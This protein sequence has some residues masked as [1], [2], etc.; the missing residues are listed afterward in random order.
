MALSKGVTPFYAWAR[1]VVQLHYCSRRRG[2][3][4]RGKTKSTLY[5]VPSTVAA[6]ACIIC[7]P[8]RCT[9]PQLT[10]RW[11]NCIGTAS[12]HGITNYKHFS[13]RISFSGFSPSNRFSRPGIARRTERAPIC[14]HGR[15]YNP[16][17]SLL[18]EGGKWQGM[19]NT[20][21]LR[22]EKGKPVPVNKVS[23]RCALSFADDFCVCVCV[24]VID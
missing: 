3:A 20:A 8:L 11:E 22:R 5:V 21:Q 17:T 14:L 9:G 1:G 2:Y 18:E 19:R 4:V 12:M 16:V 24:F 13:G 6:T 15:Y 7:C 10:H 23:G